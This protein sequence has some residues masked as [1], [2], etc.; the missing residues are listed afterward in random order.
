MVRARSRV[1]FANGGGLLAFL[2]TSLALA[3]PMPVVAAG[4]GVLSAPPTDTASGDQ[5]VPGGWLPVLADCLEERR[6]GRYAVV[7]RSTSGETALSLAGRVTALRELRPSWVLLTI[8]SR[9]LASDDADPDA[10]RAEVETVVSGLRGKARKSRPALV[11]LGL[12]P[13]SVPQVE[14]LD[15][16]LQ[17][18]LDD[19]TA[20]Y[21][22]R[23]AALAEGLDGVHHVDLWAE[24]PRE[25]GPRHALTVE[26]WSLSDQGHARVAAAVCD[27]VLS[28]R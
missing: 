22:A 12:V 26:G 23:I 4:D 17:A 9:E 5:T 19:R 21:N 3:D 10:L 7:D 6:P 15:P 25:P 20:A 2:V 11:L 1:V 14:G 24:W 18:L 13:P 16:A 27:V 8:G 28:G